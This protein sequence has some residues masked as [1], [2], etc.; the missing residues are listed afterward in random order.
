M[1]LGFPGQ[2]DPGARDL[3]ARGP[4]PSRGSGGVGEGLD[5]NAPNFFL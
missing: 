4:P 2:L 5:P 1:V 3:R